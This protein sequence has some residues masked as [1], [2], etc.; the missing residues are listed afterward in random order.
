MPSSPTYPDDLA[1]LREGKGARSKEVLSF[2]LNPAV[3]PCLPPSTFS[4]SFPLH[5]FV[6]CTCI[7]HV[8]RSVPSVTLLWLPTDPP[9]GLQRFSF[10]YV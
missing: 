4:S 2:Q 1:S 6:L 7:S 8:A 5:L 3:H 10:P 9:R